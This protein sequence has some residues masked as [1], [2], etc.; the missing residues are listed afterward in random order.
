MISNSL[1]SSRTDD[2]ETPQEFFDTDRPDPSGSNLLAQRIRGLSP[3]KLRII[4]TMI[5]SWEK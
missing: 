4:S 3:D 5:D 2:W 1:Y